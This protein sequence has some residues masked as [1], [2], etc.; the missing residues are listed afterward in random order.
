MS[1]RISPGPDH[2][3]AILSRPAL[4]AKDSGVRSLQGAFPATKDWR[5]AND[6][7][8]ISQMTGTPPG[9]PA[10]H[11]EDFSRRYAQESDIA[12]G[13]TLMGIGIAPKRLGATDPEDLVRQTFH[14]AERSRGAITPDGRIKLD[15]GIMNPDA[16]DAPYGKEAGDYWRKMRL[17]DRMQAVGAHECEEHEGGSDDEALKRGPDTSLPVSEPARE[18]LRRMR[19]GWGK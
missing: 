15:S 16:M 1:R 8:T 2:T 14:P 4:L 12:A 3:P 5:V 10:D 11:A 6:H 13:D 17:L 19:D 18:M 9:D 7:G